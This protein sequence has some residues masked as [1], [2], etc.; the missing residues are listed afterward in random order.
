MSSFL[1]S[2]KRKAESEGVGFSTETGAKFEIYYEIL[3][4][5]NARINLTALPL[6]AVPAAETL[7]RLFL[8]PLAAASLV[9]PLRI[10]C[11]D[12]GSGGGSPALPLKILRPAMVLTLIEARA[13]KAAFL[14][15]AL[16]HLGMAD[17]EV[18][19]IRIEELPH[20]FDATADLITARA[21]AIDAGVEATIQRVMQ[22]R[23]ELLLF[24]RNAPVGAFEEVDS[25]PLPGGSRAVLY[26]RK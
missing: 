15:E 8:E 10:V 26:E 11:L 12:L 19:S 18:L 1:A 9:S 5:W 20:R 6:L 17:V 14:R 2:L 24:G 22:V 7:D 13:R 23:G 3:R 16:R 25:R 21:L 4:R